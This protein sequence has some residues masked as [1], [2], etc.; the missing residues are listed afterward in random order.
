MLVEA[1]VQ[2]CRLKGIRVVYGTFSRLMHKR[3]LIDRGTE[4]SKLGPFTE[5]M[6][7]SV[8]LI[9]FRSVVFNGLP[10][11]LRS[12]CHGGGAQEL[13]LIVGFLTIES[14]YKM[15]V[16]CW[17]HEHFFCAPFIPLFPKLF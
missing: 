10:V 9:H 6:G 14:P 16:E 3:Y 8:A 12:F 17:C 13:T 2:T 1:I 11:G 5:R 4:A 15:L 7:A